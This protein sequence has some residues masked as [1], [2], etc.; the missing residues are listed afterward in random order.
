MDDKSLQN[1]GEQVAKRKRPDRS[2][3]MSIHT[4]DGDNAKFMQHGI[5]LN[6]FDKVE[7]SS[8]IAVRQRINDYF[9]VCIEDDYKP[10][11]IGLAIA[12]GVSRKYLWDIR[13]GNTNKSQ[14]VVNTIKK[15]CDIIELQMTDYMQNGK[16]N[17][18]AGIFLM[19]NNFGYAD[20]QEIE[21][22][23][24]SPLGDTND[25]KELESRY[26]DSVIIEQDGTTVIN[27]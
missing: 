11:I 25:T 22:K 6:N 26:K 27:E 24:Q 10:S 12:L 19:N 8:P 4:E 1:I 9:D 7:L 16:I 17:P 13:Q 20:K 23:A 18:V 15:A 5:K 3:A 2:E 21:V 14:E